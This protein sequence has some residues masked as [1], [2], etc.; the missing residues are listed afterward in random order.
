MTR[1]VPRVGVV[2]S[3]ELGWLTD[4]H[5]DEEARKEPSKIHHTVSVALHEIILVRSSP[6]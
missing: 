5:N 2:C 1:F 6:A 4:S 3:L